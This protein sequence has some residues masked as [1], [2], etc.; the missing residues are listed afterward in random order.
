[1]QR[2][3]LAFDLHQDGQ[4]HA[5]HLQIIEASNHE[6]EGETPGVLNFSFRSHLDRMVFSGHCILG[7][8]VLHGES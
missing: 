2:A 1:M 4:L 8:V 5:D 6:A 7:S 3:T